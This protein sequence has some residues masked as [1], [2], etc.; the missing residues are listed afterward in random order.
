MRLKDANDTGIAEVKAL[1]ADA[2]RKKLADEK[3][4]A[5]DRRLKMLDAHHEVLGLADQLGLKARVSVGLDGLPCVAVECPRV[6]YPGKP[7]HPRDPALKPHT[8]DMTIV[9]VNTLDELYA[10]LG[11]P[12]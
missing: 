4:A 9:F 1:L 7:P 5:L 11:Y 12:T 6:R 2:G 3:A 10:A 8:V